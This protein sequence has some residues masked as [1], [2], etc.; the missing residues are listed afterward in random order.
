MAGTL[1]DRFLLSALSPLNILL[2]IT[3]VFVNQKS[4]AQWRQRLYRFWTFFLF[5]LA[6]QS[7]I[8][9]FVRRSCMMEQIFTQQINVD[10]FIHSLVNALIR[11]SWIVSETIVH[12][13]LM[14]KMWPSAVLYLETLESV[15]LDFGRPDLS[16]I[17]R[18]SI[19]GLIYVLF[20]VSF[21]LK[22]N[23]FETIQ[24]IT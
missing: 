1:R 20:T 15:D 5:I 23:Y 19:Y 21:S 10:R 16:P 8:Y 14:F 12:L 9:I 3:G 24:C 18:Y 6:V 22:K 11:L 7:N 17:K 4:E 2:K 13:N